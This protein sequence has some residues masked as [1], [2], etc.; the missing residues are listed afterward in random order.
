MKKIIFLTTAVLL[1][2]LFYPLSATTTLGVATDTRI[3]IYP[4]G[5]SIPTDEYINY[6]A[7]TFYMS[8]TDEHGFLVGPSGSKLI[9]FAEEN[10]CKNHD[11]YLVASTP[12]DESLMTFDGVNFYSLG[13]KSST[14]QA[15]GY[16]EFPYYAVKLPSWDSGLWNEIIFETSKKYYLYS[17]PLVYSGTFS[18]NIGYFFAA[19]DMDNNGLLQFGKVGNQDKFSPKTSSA[20]GYPYPVPEPYTFILML[21]G[22]LGILPIT[23]ILSNRV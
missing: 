9:I 14:G 20:L 18:N 15:D 4:K 19:A 23:K 12:L 3:Y 21:F 2:L 8:S 13:E 1:V 5:S 22:I 11:L 17:A 7:D 10:V 16:T 6:F